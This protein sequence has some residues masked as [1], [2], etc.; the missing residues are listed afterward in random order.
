V[1]VKLV[2]QFLGKL[3]TLSHLRTPFKKPAGIAAGSLKKIK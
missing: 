1:L 2:P 3:I